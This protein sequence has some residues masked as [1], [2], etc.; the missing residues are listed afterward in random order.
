MDV[1]ALLRRALPQPQLSLACLR[2]R[3]ETSAPTSSQSATTVHISEAT[4]SLTNR[5]AQA[6]VSSPKAASLREFL[7][8][9]DFSSITPRQMAQVGGTLFEKGELSE[10]AASSFIGVET[11]LADELDPD[12]PIDMNK[13]FKHMLDAAAGAT[14]TV[15]GEYDFAIRLRQ[16]ASKALGDV[17]SFVNGDR[18]H[19]ST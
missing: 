16:Q 10:S 14:P 15:P 3:S 17:I 13:H 5:A 18:N 4:R 1:S 7:G 9:F 19:I 12:K 8:K 2:L 6:K 11:N